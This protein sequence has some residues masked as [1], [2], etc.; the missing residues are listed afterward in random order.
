MGTKMTH[1][2]RTELTNV[3]R[4]RYRAATGAEKGRILDEFVAVTGYHHKSAIRARNAEAEASRRVPVR[5]FADWS[6]PPPGSMEMDLV[7]HCGDVNRGSYVNSL[8]L[9][10]IASGWTE[11]APLVVRESGLV[12]ETLE[13]IRQGLP[14]AP[15]AL[16]VDNGSEFVNESLIHYCL[17]HGIELTRSRPYLKNEQAWIEQKNAAVV[18]KPLGTRPVQGIAAARAITRLYAASRLFVNFFQPS[19][20][21]AQKHLH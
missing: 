19:L 11:A 14:F 17:S 18:P 2:A 10:D 16:D 4:R 7:A 20:K 15:R 12:V 3:V 6:E 8:V 13:R 21:L 9:T 1:T 5:T